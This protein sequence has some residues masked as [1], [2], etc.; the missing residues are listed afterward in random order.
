LIGVSVA[1]MY[2]SMTIIKGSMSQKLIIAHS[3]TAFFVA[4]VLKLNTV[5]IKTQDNPI[6]T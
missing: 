2:I 4:L 1:G 5:K 6:A 3:V